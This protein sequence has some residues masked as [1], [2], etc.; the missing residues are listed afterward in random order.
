MKSITFFTIHQAPH[1]TFIFQS[2]ENSFFLNVFYYQQKLKNYGWEIND[3]FYKKNEKKG[4]IEHIKC[5]LSSDLVVISGWSN[6][7]HIL[8]IVLMLLFQRKFAIFMDFGINNLRKNKK[9]KKY[10][11]K[12]TPIILVTGIYGEKFLR[13]YLN[14]VDVYNFPY[15]VK[16][17]DHQMV[18]QI[19]QRRIN[20]IKIGNRLKVFISNRFIER[21]GYHLIESLINYLKK[22]NLIN[23]I[24]FCIAGNGPLFEK[25][26]QSISAISDNIL[27]LNWID[28]N[29]YRNNML[30][31][32]IYIHC[33]EYEP[34]GIPPV[35]AFMC[36]KEI[37]LTKKIYSKYDILHYG[38]KFYEFDYKKEDELHNILRTIIKNRASIYESNKER[39]PLHKYLFTEIH[40]KVINDILNGY[41]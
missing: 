37:I 21:K 41:C 17:F 22:E 16:N 31:C 27:F 9:I 20:D 5:A 12:L 8:L 24:Q 29:E 19:N 7:K 39:V 13:R 32:D 40:N 18:N 35:D 10:V 28:Y 6:S 38:G 2:L 23:Q 30:N 11:L 36:H 25:Y 3:F 1:N 4:I 26:K 33:S 14:K 34:Y 15:G